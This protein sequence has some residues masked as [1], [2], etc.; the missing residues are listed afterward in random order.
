MA[1]ERLTWFGVTYDLSD[2]TAL[3]D[4][5]PST[6]SNQSF[7]NIALLKNYDYSKRYMTLEHNFTLL[8]GV[9][10]EINESVEDVAFFSDELAD[11]NG[12]FTTNPTVTVNFTTYHSSFALTLYF[13]EEH[14]LKVRVQ[15]YRDALKITDKT[16]DVTDPIQII[17]TDV[18]LYNKIVIEFVKVLPYH[19]AKLYAVRYGVVVEW[20][21]SNL[22]KGT[23]VQELN[24][25]SEKIPI[26]TLS[27]EVVDVNHGLNFGNVDGVHK[28]YQRNQEMTPYELV[29]GERINFGK[30]Y[31]SKFSSEKNLGKM[32][33]VSVMGI[34]DAI[35]FNSGGVYPNGT[36]AGNL[37]RAIFDTAKIENYSIDSETENTIVYGSLPPMSCRNALKEVLFACNSVIDTSTD[38]VSIYKYKRSVSSEIPRSMKFS[39]KITKNKYVSGVEIKF[40]TYTLSQETSEAL[41]DSYD[42]GEHTAILST[43]YSNITVSGATLESATPYRVTFTCAEDSEVII[44][45]QKYEKTQASVVQ[46]APYIEPGEVE[47]V[48]TFT[49]KLC[50]A[51]T[52]TSLAALLLDYLS[53]EKLIFNISQLAV[54][55][56]MNGGANIEN[57]VARYRGFLGWYNKR[58]FDLT[59]GYTDTAQLYGNYI[60]DDMYYYTGTELYANNSVII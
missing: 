8:D 55:N 50:N 7:G 44:S 19:Y 9:Q 45:G 20:D 31:L 27:F 3:G 18:E 29:N 43:P 14:P 1:E 36:S 41:K 22:K 34:L 56:D 52:A 24:R 5:T 40:D 2:M 21:E 13:D 37:I 30:F 58:T 10:P 33:S 15:W 39:T 11:A 32:T 35:Q 28:Y 53:K 60:E 51:K 12:E 16:Y 6:S 38:P 42:A 46:N 59:G 57:P 49:A 54:D 17:P 26:N 47:S 23:I 48:K 4:S 25:I